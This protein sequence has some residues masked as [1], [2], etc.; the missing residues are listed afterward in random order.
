VCKNNLYVCKITYID[1]L[2]NLSKTDISD[3]S[4]IS[5]E[6]DFS[7]QTETKEVIISEEYNGSDFGKKKK[8]KKKKKIK[9]IY[10]KIYFLKFKIKLF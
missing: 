7:S 1:I 9:N 6:S 2:S 10:I 3:I 8:K 4:S 5:T